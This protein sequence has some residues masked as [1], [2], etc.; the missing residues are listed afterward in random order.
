MPNPTAKNA[1][2]HTASSADT[3]VSSKSLP[4]PGSALPGLTSTGGADLNMLW[5][6]LHT[7]A[8]TLPVARDEGG[9]PLGLQLASTRNSDDR[10]LAIADTVFTSLRPQIWR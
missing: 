10:L 4:K 9:L 3:A 7:P 5:T 8:I 6:S 2:E 1:S